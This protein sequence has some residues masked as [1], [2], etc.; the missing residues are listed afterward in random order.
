MI[1]ESTDS[2]IM[3]QERAGESELHSSDILPKAGTV[4]LCDGDHEIYRGEWERLG[5]VFADSVDDLFIQAQL[6]EG[7]RKAPGDNAYGYW[8]YLLDA[9]GCRRAAIF[10]K[11]A[12][13]DRSAFISPMPRYRSSYHPGTLEQPA[14]WSLDP[15]GT[16][17]YAVFDAAQPHPHCQ[18]GTPIYIAGECANPRRTQEEFLVDI[19][20]CDRLKIDARHWLETHFPDNDN[21]FAYWSA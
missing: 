8:T 5:F 1:G 12:F 19:A 14:D 20:V 3:E 6:P 18:N 15:T 13:Y 16:R 4:E 17:T 10:Y 11:A 7:W 21:P 2:I 9:R